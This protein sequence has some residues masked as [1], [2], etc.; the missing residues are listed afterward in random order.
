MLRLLSFLF[1]GCFHKWVEDKRTM[2]VR[3]SVKEIPH[4]EASY[5][6]CEKCGTRKVFRLV[7]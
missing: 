6:H 3:G 7:P 2:L 4:G 1:T 5:C